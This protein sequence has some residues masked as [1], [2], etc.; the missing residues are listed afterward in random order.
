MARVQ[1]VDSTLMDAPKR[2]TAGAELTPEQLERQRQQ[3][4]FS[5]LISQLED[6]SVVF[7]VRLGKDEKPIT[8]RQRLLRAAA[9]ADRE[10]AVRRSPNGFLVGLMTADRR[11]KSRTQEGFRRLTAVH[12]SGVGPSV[13]LFGRRDS[14]PTQRAVRFFR[15]R[16]VPIIQVDL[17]V[18]RPAPTELRRFSERLGVRALLDTEAAAYR[19]LGLAYLRMDDHEVF[20][21]VLGDPRLLRLPLARF[22]SE[23]TVGVDEATW[24]R[25]AAAGR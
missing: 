14:R 10:V 23:V 11:S 20:E 22:G 3:R 7:E 25:W 1:R 6:P 17:D 18:R 2:R 15:E 24:R 5:R 8:V 13:Q 16:R 4:Q 12:V 9:D 21:R 19:D